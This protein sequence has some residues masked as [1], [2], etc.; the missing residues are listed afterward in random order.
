[1][2]RFAPLMSFK[3]TK[4]MDE[5]DEF[6]GLSEQCL[7]SIVINILDLIAAD[8]EPHHQKVST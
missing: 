5:L 4:V 1:M 7:K 3:N 8:A 6:D 2:L